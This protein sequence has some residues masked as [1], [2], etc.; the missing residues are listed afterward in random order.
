MPPRLG[1]VRTADDPAAD[2]YV[3]QI[4]RAFRER[5]LQ[6]AVSALGQA[7]GDE[8]LARVLQEIASERSTHGILVQ[9]P[10]PP[11]LSLDVVVK[12]LPSEKDVEGLHPVNAA[13]LA[14]GRPSIVPST[15]LAG[16]EI[17][18][19]GGIEVAAATAVV[20]G[21]SAIV[22]RPMAQL[23]LQHDATVV[24]CHSRTRSL[25]ELTRQAE[26]LVVAAGRPRLITTSDVKP[27]ATV[28]DFGINVVDGEIVGDV[29]FG[30]VSEV[31]GA[32]TPV[33]GGTGPVT[34]AVLA[35]N[36][37]EIAERQAQATVQ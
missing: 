17:L 23:L 4:E 24:I 30:A 35:R 8:E 37:M 19:L 11:T 10:L 13:A 31:A 14:Q 15:P 12:H 21:R 34:T 32:I 33:P 25:S 36:L 1:I 20:I 29:D 5:G 2:S 27:G 22:G 6:T 9:L 3:G 28:I 16:L 7:G 18:R 26:I